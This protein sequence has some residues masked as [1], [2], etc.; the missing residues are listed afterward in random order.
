MSPRPEGPGGRIVIDP[1]ELREASARM[2]GAAALL[3]SAGR[4]LALRQPPAMPAGVSALVAETLYRANSELQE[5]AAELIEEA[6]GLTARAMWAELGA[7]E[8]IGWLIPGLHHLSAS[9]RLLSPG[10]GSPLPPAT[11]D[12]ISR[13]TEWAVR[14][15]ESMGDQPA[16]DPTSI[17][18]AALLEG[19]P[20]ADKTP[21]LPDPTSFGGFT[22]AVDPPEVYDQSGDAVPGI[23]AAGAMG[24]LSG[25]ARSDPSGMGLL[26]CIFVGFRMDGEG[27]DG[28]AS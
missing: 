8:T 6:H 13:S 11:G 2:R 15:L 18:V 9:P 23:Q 28:G 27:S 1:H 7:G 10:P 17:D 5:L 12:Q 22:L 25:E 21:E 24:S 26:G 4:D 16:A 19:F 20:G 3:S 14:L